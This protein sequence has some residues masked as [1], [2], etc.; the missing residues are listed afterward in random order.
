MIRESDTTA[1]D[2]SGILPAQMT[3]G[4]RWNC[5]TSGPRALMLAVLEDAVQCIERGRRSRRFRTQ[6]LAAEAHAWVRS[7]DR[8][9]PFSF[10]N[11]CDVLGFDADALRRRLSTMRDEASDGHRIRVR[12]PIRIRAMTLAPEHRRA[13]LGGMR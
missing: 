7:D 6:R 5:D 9:W 8:H 1:C 4:V 10:A 3:V 13:N 12:A 11:V 2:A